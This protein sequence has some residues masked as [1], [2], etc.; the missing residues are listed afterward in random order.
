[1]KQE[2]SAALAA[3]N[4]NGSLDAA[5]EAL[6]DKL[7][8]DV[9]FT[10]PHEARKREELYLQFRTIGTLKEVIQAAINTVEVFD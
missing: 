3:A 9:F 7:V 6:K 2:H 10:E 8:R 4:H 1:M 5:L